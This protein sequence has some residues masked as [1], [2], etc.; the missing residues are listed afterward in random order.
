[1]ATKRPSKYERTEE[2]TIIGLI[3]TAHSIIEELRDEL[4][5]VIQNMEEHFSQT[6]RFSRYQE[7]KDALDVC[8]VVD[9][10]VPGVASDFFNRPYVH[11]YRA[12]PKASR[13]DRLEAA[14]LRLNIARELLD[15]EIERVSDREDD[16]A[17]ALYDF[18]N[19]VQELLDQTEGVEFP[20]MFG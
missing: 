14:N 7:A 2:T 17:A 4:D 10:S 11:T 1:M 16:Y 18:V 19:I 8:D 13:S 6:E 5:D 15:E 9:L 3:E 12:K 20:G